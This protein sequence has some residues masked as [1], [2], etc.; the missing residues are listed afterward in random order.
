MNAGDRRQRIEDLCHAALEQADG[1][2]TAFAATACGSDDAL[3]REVEALFAHAQTAEGFLATPLAALAAQTLSEGPA[4][5][6][7]PAVRSLSDPRAPRLGW[8]GRD[9]LTAVLRGDH[10]SPQSPPSILGNTRIGLVR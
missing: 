8:D 1:S 9:T 5:L 7:G 6:V 10:R 3:R 4:W 2:R